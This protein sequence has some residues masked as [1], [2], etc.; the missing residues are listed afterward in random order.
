MR[1]LCKDYDRYI[2]NFPESFV[3]QLIFQQNSTWEGA[4]DTWGEDQN[5]YLKNQLMLHV[6]SLEVLLLKKILPVKFHA[7]IIPELWFQFLK[8]YRSSF[9]SKC[10]EEW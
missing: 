7:Q 6:A 1:R 3:S 8:K 9:K 10:K 2:S 4:N 5:T